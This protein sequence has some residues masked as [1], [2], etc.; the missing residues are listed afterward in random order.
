[1]TRRAADVHR[2]RK[3]VRDGIAAGE[4]RHRDSNIKK[5]LLHR[6]QLGWT[7]KGKECPRPKILDLFH[8]PE[9]KFERLVTAKDRHFYLEE[10]FGLVDSFDLTRERTKRPVDNAHRLT[11]PEDLPL[12]P[13]L[14]FLEIVVHPVTPLFRS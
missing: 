4:N 14:P 3:E 1:M 7:R 5:S 11:Q 6:L 2:A 12:S 9:T 13:V 10:G 8:S